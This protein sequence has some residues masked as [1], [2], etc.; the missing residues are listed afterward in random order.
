MSWASITF[1]FS[2]G[3]LAFLSPCAFPLLP[4]YISYYLGLGEEAPRKT[5][6]VTSTL[7]KGFLGGL[8]C[9]GGA[10]AVLGIIGIVI[11]A[12]GGAITPHIPAMELTVG[13]ALILLGIAMLSGTMPHF[14][15]KIGVRM[16]RGYLSL[17]GFGA[18][19]A[20]ASAGCVAPIFIGVILNA[21][22]AGGLLGGM[23]V[24]FSYI[25]GLSALLI[26]VTILIAAAKEIALTHLK[27]AMPYIQRVGGLILITV[28][29]Y[30]VCYY[31]TVF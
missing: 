21:L 17:F 19:Y 13:G 24:F 18:L 5:P 25:L 23:T 28:G 8:V 3:V 22:S 9:A 1:A 30:L 29:I 11:S 4:A 16:S 15:P 12:F 7:K 20:L 2:A 14:Y 26:C 6:E 31:F 27:R 10:L